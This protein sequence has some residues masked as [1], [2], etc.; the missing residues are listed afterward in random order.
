MPPS[1]QGRGPQDVG[2]LLAA[3]EIFAALDADALE[4]IARGAVRRRYDAGQVVFLEGEPCTGLYVVEEGWLKAVKASP[5]GREQVVRLVG[6]GEAFN[7]VG[8]LV[9]APNSATVIALES[10][11]LW[12]VR[13]GV[14][15]RLLDE[16][17]PIARAVIEALARRVLHLM[18]MVEDLSL[19][20]VEARLARLLLE[21]ATGGVVRR[22]K[23]TTQAEMASRVGTV[24][25]VLNRALHALADEGLIEVERHEIRVLDPQGLAARAQIGD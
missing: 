18:A 8:V 4:S 20:T 17:P 6:P 7:A 1:T 22:R 24:L 25:D 23:W 15:L 11:T 21:E 13:S 5:S 3:T 10:V 2:K 16:H 19:R 9:G 14:L 12:I